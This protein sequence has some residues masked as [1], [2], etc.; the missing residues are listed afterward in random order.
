MFNPFAHAETEAPVKLAVELW[1]SRLKARATLTKDGKTRD[2]E[3]SAPIAAGLIA[4]LKPY[5][6]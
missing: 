4:F 3:I 1:P 5:L 6:K 2:V